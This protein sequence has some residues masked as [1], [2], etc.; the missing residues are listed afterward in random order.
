MGLPAQKPCQYVRLPH[1]VLCGQKISGN[2]PCYLVLSFPTRKDPVVTQ[3]ISFEG[4][5]V[6]YLEGLSI[7]VYSQLRRRAIYTPAIHSLCKAAVVDLPI[8]R[9]LSNLTIATTPLVWTGIPQEI[10]RTYAFYSNAIAALFKDPRRKN[11]DGML[12]ELLGRCGNLPVELGVIIWDFL[13]PSAI[14]CLLALNATKS[15]WSCL[16]HST[17]RATISLHGELVV[18]FT[19]I[20]KGTY[21]CGIRQGHILYGHMGNSSL[22][23]SVPASSTACVFSLGTYG[24]QKLKFLTET[25]ASSSNVDDLESSKL[26]HVVSC[27]RTRPVCVDI[28]WDVWKISM[29]SSHDKSTFG[30]DFFWLSPVP[31]SKLHWL[32]PEL[33]YDWPRHFDFAT[34]SR[35]YMTY[36]PLRKNQLLYGITAFCSDKGLVGLGTHHR[37]TEPREQ[38]STVSWYGEQH[39]CPIHIQFDCSDTITSIYVYWHQSD[40]LYNRYLAITTSKDRQYFLGPS[41]T[42]SKTRMQKIYGPEDGEILGLYYDVSPGLPSFTSLGTIC[43][44]LKSPMESKHD[45]QPQMRQASPVVDLLNIRIIKA[46]YMNSRCTGILLYYN[47][48]AIRILGR[49]YES[50]RIQPDIEEIF[51]QNDNVLR[52]YLTYTD[53]QLSLIRVKA[54]PRTTPLERDIVFLDILYGNEIVWLFSEDSDIIFCDPD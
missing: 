46:C 53:N 6:I 51:F 13:N 15:I 22:L 1:C 49:W 20:L 5:Q 33:F 39:G 54:L 36:I 48:D 24:L 3:A 31:C 37:S 17:G 41:F 23:I 21:I 18:Y 8:P 25:E 26:F 27:R 44:P 16:P 19:N 52:F 12:L 34:Q 47:D 38:P 50:T 2:I 7:Q 32:S 10:Y 11:D 4:T 30:H 40:S 43:Q 42:P 9:T 45:L 28:D 29:A 14:R 35:R